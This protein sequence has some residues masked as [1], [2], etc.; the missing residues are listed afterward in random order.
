M[1]DPT[2]YTGAGVFAVIVAA[3]TGTRF[4]S[5]M[6]KQFLP[7]GTSTVLMTTVDAFRRALP[8]AKIILMLSADGHAIWDGLC[9][10]YAYESPATATGGSSRSETVVRALVACRAAGASDDSIILIHDGARPLVSPRL[11]RSL[12]RCVAEGNDAAVP[13]YTPTDSMEEMSDGYGVPRRRDNYCCVQTPQ[14]F[15][16]GVIFRAYDEALKHSDSRLDS[17]DD[18]TVAAQY[19]ACRIVVVD[20]ER[21]NIKITHPDDIAVAELFMARRAAES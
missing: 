1:V 11:I 10:R 3:G 20:G 8:R 12:A 21:T 5:D 16:A 2:D 15:R 19:G 18:A 4:G 6:P 17:S 14:T 13:G 7:L 9:R